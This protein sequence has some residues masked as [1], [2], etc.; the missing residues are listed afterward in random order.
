M[1]TYLSI[2]DDICPISILI[3]RHIS[4]DIS[5]LHGLL[6]F[7]RYEARGFSQKFNTSLEHTFETFFINPCYMIELW[8]SITTS[9]CLYTSNARRRE[10]GVGRRRDV[11][12]IECN[13]PSVTW[14]E[15]GARGGQGTGPRLCGCRKRRWPPLWRS[16]SRA[17]PEQPK[18]ATKMKKDKTFGKSCYSLNK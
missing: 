14:V 3:K 12:V 7:L 9:A 16:G 11:L 13:A 2:S 8:D 6:P 4:L 10:A 18:I 15:G 5:A 17:Q 1:T